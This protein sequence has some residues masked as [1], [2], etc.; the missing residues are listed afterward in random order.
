[1]SHKPIILTYLFIAFF[2][3][4]F[5][6]LTENWI[7]IVIGLLS[8]GSSMIIAGFLLLLREKKQWQP[9]PIDK[10]TV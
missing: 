5:I 9:F 3:I 10:E 1:M 2:S 7:F 8:T 6:N 4:I